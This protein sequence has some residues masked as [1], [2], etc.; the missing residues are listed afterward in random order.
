MDLVVIISIFDSFIGE[1]M[2]MGEC[3]LVVLINV[4]AFGCM[5]IGEV[6][7]NIVV[8]CIGKLVDVCLL[9]NWMCV[10]GYFGED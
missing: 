3:I 8:V 2:V 9:V 1:V 4:L 7:M 5:V 10:V 6:I